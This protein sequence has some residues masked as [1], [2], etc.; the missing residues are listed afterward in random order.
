M[1]ELTIGFNGDFRV[2]DHPLESQDKKPVFIDENVN[3]FYGII[4]HH[5]NDSVMIALLLKRVL[6]GTAYTWTENDE[7][8][9][10]CNSE[11]FSYIQKSLD[12]EKIDHS[13]LQGVSEWRRVHGDE[14]LMNT[15]R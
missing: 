13:M 15:Y 9:F 5:R 2:K 14:F 7:F 10:W 4:A 12:V 11:E 1:D 8:C 3:R 6:M